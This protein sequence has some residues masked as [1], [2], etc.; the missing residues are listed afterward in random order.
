MTKKTGAK[1]P[2]GA[3]ASAATRITLTMSRENAGKYWAV[4]LRALEGVS[5][6]TLGIFEHAHVLSWTIE[7][8]ELGFAP[9]DEMLAEVAS[10]ADKVSTLRRVIRQETSFEPHIDIRVMTEQDLKAIRGPEHDDAAEPTLE[11]VLAELQRRKEA[12]DVLDDEIT[13]MIKES[14]E[15]LRGYITV[16]ISTRLPTHVDE[17]FEEFLAYGKADGKWSLL[18]IREWLNGSD[19]IDEMPLVNAS[20]ER[21][22]QV[23]ADGYLERLIREAITHLDKQISLRKTAIERGRAVTKA[24]NISRGGAK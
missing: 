16:R 5:I 24:L 22:M 23:L 13:A 10:D 7:K 9:A 1:A 15:A 8:L 6:T 20:R 12:I 14:E 4:V 21:R 11:V 19:N 18:I 3:G 2:A 17:H